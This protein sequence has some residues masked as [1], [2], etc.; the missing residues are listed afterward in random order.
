M[1]AVGIQLTEAEA[2]KQRLLQLGVP[3]AAIILLPEA[4]STREEV[5]ALN[6]YF[7]D[8][9]RSSLLLI[10][11]QTHT[12]R[13]L[14]VFKEYADAWDEIAAYGVP[15]THYDPHWWWKNEYG[16]LAVYEEYLKLWYYWFAY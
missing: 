15:P 8:K 6:T 14:G 3:E 10:T 1:A 4:T 2:A 12:R 9:R 16:F 11:T 7:K 13:A 5:N